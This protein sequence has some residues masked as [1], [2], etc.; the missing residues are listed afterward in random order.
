MKKIISTLILAILG[1]TVSMAQQAVV[2]GTIL[3]SLSREGEPAAI[4]QFF[5]APDMEKPIAFTTTDTDGHFTQN[6]TGK[7]S[8]RLLFSNMGRKTVTRD[9]TLDGT[10]D[11]IDLGIIPVQDDVQTLKAGSITAQRPLVRMEVD[12]MT[13]DVAND[14]DSK[15]S[16]VLD[17]LRKVPMVSVD[18]QDNIT[19]NGSSSFQVYVDGKPNPMISSNPSVVFKMMPASAVKDISVVTNPGVRYDAEGVGGVLQ[20]TTN[21]EVTGGQ[22]VAD[23][24][25]GTLTADVS[26]RGGGAGAFYSRQKGK[27]AM[28]FTGNAIFNNSPGTTVDVERTTTAGMTTSMHS[29]GTMKTPIALGNLNLSYDIDSLNLIS[30]TAGLMRLGTVSDNTGLTTMGFGGTG[31]SYTTDTWSKSNTGS[32][33]ASADYQHL[34]A[35]SPNRSFVLSYQFSASPS[36]SDSRN[37]FKAADIPALDLTDRRTDGRTNSLDHTVQAD[38]TTPIDGVGTLSTGVKFI[39]RH[40]LSD[41]QNYIW[42]E[43]DWKYN[44]PGS[45]KYDYYNRI[46]AAYTEMSVNLGPFG[47]KAGARYEHTWQRYVQD[48]GSDFRAGYGF[49]VPSA[50]IQYNLGMTSNIGLSYNLRISRPGITYLNPY[51]DDSDPTA[52]SYGN[53]DLEVERGHTVNLVYNYFTTSLMLNL[54]A[55]WSHVG[56]GISAYSFYQDNVLHTTYGNIVSTTGT[57]L[58]AFMMINAGAKTRIIV[59]GGVDYNDLRSDILGQSNSGWSGNGLLGFQQTLPWDL[60]LSANAILMSKSRNLQGWSTGISLGTLGLTK[61][62]LDDRLSVSLS[63]ISPLGSGSLAIKS[64]SETK[65]FVSDMSLAVPIR[66][67][68]L[69]VNWTFGKQGSANVKKARRTITND[70][71]INTQSTAETLNGSGALGGGSAAGSLPAG[72]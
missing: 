30:A 1:C 63:A 43:N 36:V 52:L 23:G 24:S 15:T 59:N 70:D 39:S 3:D 41:Q 66:Q 32:I 22:S 50:S 57:G 35:D 10:S 49:L 33:T 68:S 38:F 7:G 14:V 4:I 29:E 71:V 44:A 47:L 17:M 53:P 72:L 27:F 46:G 6:L 55:R 19:V 8:Y 40:N 25:Y 9:F 13:Y 42:N 62:F 21:R 67:A 69:S 12:K 5:K 16:T 20:I 45:T 37:L 2:T 54:T 65:E 60:R 34:W 26:T 28:S 18:G 51:R 31:F 48:G 58:N 11:N 56:N 64:H 61:T